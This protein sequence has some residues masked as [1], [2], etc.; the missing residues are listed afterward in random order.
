LKIELGPF[1]HQ[2]VEY[3]AAVLL[4]RAMQSGKEALSELLV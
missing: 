3:L 4:P 2:A 1:G